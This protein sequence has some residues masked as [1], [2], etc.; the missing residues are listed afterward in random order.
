M[1]TRLGKS[2]GDVFASVSNLVT[3]LNLFTGFL[4]ILM[5]A[6][7]HFATA[8]WLVLLALVWDSLDGKIARW[9]G[10]QTRL[11][12]ELDS[13]ADV[14]SFVVAPCALVSQVFLL[15]ISPTLLLVV[16]FYLAAGMFRLARFN[17][18]PPVHNFFSGLP[19]P[20]AGLT[21]VMFVLACLR[22]GWTDLPV[23]VAGTIFLM[24]IM[25]LLMVSE[26]PYPKLSALPFKVW[27]AFLYAEV[28][29]LLAVTMVLN[30]ES[31]CALVLLLFV[32]F[33]PALGMSARRASAQGE[34]EVNPKVIH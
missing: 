23:C 2:F 27:K 12:C 14:V 30:F 8:G 4:S 3:F 17:V 19:T 13:L 9:F 22:E 18:R 24:G 7:N 5:T 21:L 20:A 15:K 26:I 32:F 29:V 1:K 28:L 25:G 6:R 16:F 10:R 31:A 33:S 34:D 11:G